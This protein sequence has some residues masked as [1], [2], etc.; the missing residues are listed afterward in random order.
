MEGE[1]SS[2]DAPLGSEN[3]GFETKISPF[4]I[5]QTFQEANATIMSITVDKILGNETE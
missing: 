1:F 4:W 5:P 3:I 2:A